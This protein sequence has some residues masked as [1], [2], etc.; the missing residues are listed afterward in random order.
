MSCALVTPAGTSVWNVHV[1]RSV[2][3]AIP[4][5]VELV[6]HPPTLGE[7]ECLS[8]E[9]P[10]RRHVCA[11]HRLQ[12]ARYGVGHAVILLVLEL[13]LFSTGLGD[14]V[15]ACAAVAAGGAPLR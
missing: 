1:F 4:K 5:L 8:N 9:T 11:S 10:E 7:R 14:L 6:V 2:L 3:D 13:E 15:V 12:H